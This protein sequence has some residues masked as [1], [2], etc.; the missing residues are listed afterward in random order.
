MT[1]KRYT[2]NKVW[3]DNHKEHVQAYQRTWRKQHTKSI[4]L[5]NAQ[6]RTLARHIVT[7]A[8]Q[9]PCKDCGIQYKPWQM[10]FDHLRNKLCNIGRLSLSNLD[11]VREEIAKC[12]V[13]C[14]N[15]HRDRTYKR[16]QFYGK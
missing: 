14:A 16:G 9:V 3:Y 11:T 2:Y 4:A 1:A 12:E 10:D 6:R 5:Y 8:K 13:V 7:I 15:C